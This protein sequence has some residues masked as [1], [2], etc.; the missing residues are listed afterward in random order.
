MR[1]ILAK[2]N[3]ADAL[4]KSKNVSQALQQM[5]NTNRIVLES[6]KWIEI[7]WWINHKK[8]QKWRGV[9][10][11]TCLR[12]SQVLIKYDFIT[13]ILSEALYVAIVRVRLPGVL[14]DLEISYYV[15][16][17]VLYIN[18]VSAGHVFLDN[19]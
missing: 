14:T 3:P 11:T 16:K 2:N 6:D 18:H 7:D 1:W 5:I 17:V 9:L 15:I 8:K 12:L 19:R 4:T 10:A 13:Y